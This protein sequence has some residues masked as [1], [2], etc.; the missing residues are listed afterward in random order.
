[1][2]TPVN[3]VCQPFDSFPK[4]SSVLNKAPAG[5]R[6]DDRGVLETLMAIT[7]TQPPLKIVEVLLQVANKQRRLAGR[8]YDGRVVRVENL[9]DV[10]GG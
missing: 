8:G 1:M 4:V 6:K 3:E 7:F 5:T 9:L 10:V 2:V